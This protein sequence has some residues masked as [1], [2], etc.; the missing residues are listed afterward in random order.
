MQNNNNPRDP[1]QDLLDG[2]THRIQHPSF[3]HDISASRLPSQAATD[4]SSPCPEPPPR[5]RHHRGPEVEIEDPPDPARN[6]SAYNA[7]AAALQHSLEHAVEQLGLGVASTTVAG[8]GSFQ[9]FDHGHSDLVLAV[10]FDFYGT[11]MV[12]ASSDQRLRVWDRKE[13]EWVITDAWR[14]H[15]AEIVDVKFNGPFTTPTFASIAEDSR[16]KVWTEDVLQVPNSSHRFRCIYTFRSETGVPFCSLDFKSLMTETYLATITRDGYLAVYHPV[17][18]DELSTEWGRME[19]M[20]V[21]VTPSRAEETG[22]RVS[23]HGENMPC[24]TAVD[25]GLDRHALSLAVAAMDVVKIY[26][27]DKDKKFYLAAEL[28]GA[29]NI[30]RDLGWANGAMRGYDLIAAAS[31][32]GVVRIYEVSTPKPGSGSAAASSATTATPGQQAR[33]T[34][35][36]SLDAAGAAGEAPS[37]G[38]TVPAANPQAGIVKHVVKLVGEVGKEHGGVWRL[39]WSFSGDLLVTTG[40]DGSIRAWKRSVGGAW[41]EAAQVDVEGN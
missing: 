6:D 27:T 2:A 11:R 25:A 30:I 8:P 24:W 22:F 5:V 32:D 28:T 19:A 33:G 3:L 18:F 40:D 35:S 20:H 13:Q 29:R 23:W 7:P 26:R 39:A 12:T 17:D 41:L 34:A 10:D 14:A 37:N 15:D 1:I 21:C 9:T 4:S 16:L 36:V 38:G 31:K